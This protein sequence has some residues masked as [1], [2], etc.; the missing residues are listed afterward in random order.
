MPGCGSRARQLNCL[1]AQHNWREAGCQVQDAAVGAG[2]PAGPVQPVVHGPQPLNRIVVLD[3][4]IRQHDRDPIVGFLQ[5]AQRVRA[6]LFTA[7][8]QHRPEAFGDR[9]ER[10]VVGAHSELS[11][12]RR[13]RRRGERAPSGTA[14]WW[15]RARSTTSATAGQ[16]R[17]ARVLVTCRR[18]LKPA[19]ARR[20][21]PASGLA[22]WRNL[23]GTNVI[24]EH[25]A[26]GVVAEPGE[27][28]GRRDAVGQVVVDLHQDRPLV[29]LQ[30]LDD[31]ALPQRA[32]QVEGTL[33]GVGD[34]PEQFGVVARAGNRHPAHMMGEV[35]SRIVDPLLGAVERVVRNTCVHRGID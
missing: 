20:P 2:Y 28:V 6:R 3:G 27:Q 4:Q 33:Q 30:A 13:R 16:H 26:V 17:A 35:E 15:P 32:V 11:R 8:Q 34:G 1:G 24:G 10:D 31:P 12:T 14:A 7:V 25:V 5:G 18:P 22:W 19:T 23:F 9:R 21:S 29:A